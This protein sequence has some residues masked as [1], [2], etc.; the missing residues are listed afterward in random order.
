VIRIE[1][2]E[3]ITS[4]RIEFHGNERVTTNLGP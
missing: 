3:R 1:P 2:G 4:R